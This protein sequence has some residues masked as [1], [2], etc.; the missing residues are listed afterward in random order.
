MGAPTQEEI[1]QIAEGLAAGLSASQIATKLGTGRTRNSIVG[2]VYRYEQLAKI[3]FRIGNGMRA[4]RRNGIALADRMRARRKRT[5]NPRPRKDPKPV[6]APV[7][8]P[9]IQAAEPVVEIEEAAT[10]SSIGLLDLTATT[11]KWPVS[12]VGED[13]LFCGARK[14]PDA[15]PYCMHHREKAKGERS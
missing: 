12:G 10:P 3:G 1:D 7:D 6:A 13:T 15:G 2:I 8:L 4:G 5:E 9:S 14:Q 11:C